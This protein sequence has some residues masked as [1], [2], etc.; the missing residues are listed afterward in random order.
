MDC[1]TAGF[2]VHHQHLQFTQTYVC[3]VGEAL[4]HLIL[5]CPLLLPP[6]IF[7]STRVLSNESVLCIRWPKYWSFSFNVSPSNEYSG[8]ISF[9][10]DQLDILAVQWD[11]KCLLQ[12]HIESINSSAC[13]RKSRTSKP[14]ESDA[15]VEAGLEQRGQK[16]RRAVTSR[17]WKEAGKIL[18]WRFQKK[19]ALQAPW[20]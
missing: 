1:R 18:P 5:C 10:I 6:S 2:P 9:R 12:H 14:R 17:S 20:C 19:P 13:K 16:S 3:W 4:N 7:P 8:L 11:C 15:V